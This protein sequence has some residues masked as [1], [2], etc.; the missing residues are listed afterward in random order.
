[1]ALRLRE[2]HAEEVPVPLDPQRRHQRG[3]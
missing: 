1:V 2:R 3:A